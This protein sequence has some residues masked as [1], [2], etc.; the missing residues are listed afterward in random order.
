MLL[1]HRKASR[2]SN[3]Q[4]AHRPAK[5]PHM[6]PAEKRPFYGQTAQSYDLLDWI[7]AP[8]QSSL[9]ALLGVSA[10]SGIVG[11]GKLRHWRITSRV[12]QSVFDSWGATFCLVSVRTKTSGVKR[13]TSSV[14]RIFGRRVRMPGLQEVKASRLPPHPTIT[15]LCSHPCRGIKHVTTQFRQFSHRQH[16]DTNIVIGRHCLFSR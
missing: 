5:R 2:N 11:A 4:R 9:D 14:G 10:G 3:I 12:T 7:A 8:H 16:A 15:Q 6:E 13:T 1:H